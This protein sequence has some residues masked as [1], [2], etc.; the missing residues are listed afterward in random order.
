MLKKPQIGIPWDQ[1]RKAA[2][3]KLAR[4]FRL[5]PAVL[6][7]EVLDEFLSC[8]LRKRELLELGMRK[9]VSIGERSLLGA[10]LINARQ[11]VSHS[12]GDAAVAQVESQQQ[13]RAPGRSKRKR[14]KV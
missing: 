8:Y 2:W 9:Y 10:A 6:A 11:G 5:P 14:K 13:E 12:A 7:R 4:E 3:E 1:D